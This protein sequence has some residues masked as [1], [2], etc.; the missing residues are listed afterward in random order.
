[1]LFLQIKRGSAV[2][3]EDHRREEG[4]D[5]KDQPQQPGKIVTVAVVDVLKRQRDF[6]RCIKAHQQ[7]FPKPALAM[8]INTCTF[9]YTLAGPH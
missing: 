4:G 7:T 9:G 2:S 1:M 5:Q 3:E 6:P 8:Q